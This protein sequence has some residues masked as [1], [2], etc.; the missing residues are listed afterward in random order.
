MKYK[1]IIILYIKR[2]NNTINN[3][4]NDEKP[5]A[6]RVQLEQLKNQLLWSSSFDGVIHKSAF[7]TNGYGCFK[8]LLA[9]VL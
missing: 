6:F 2:G 4:H 7:A 3:K 5:F 1:K 8:T 9:L